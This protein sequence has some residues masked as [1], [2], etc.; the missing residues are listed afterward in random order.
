[1]LFLFSSVVGC[2]RMTG[3]FFRCSGSAFVGLLGL[4]DCKDGEVQS[5][6]PFASVCSLYFLI[7][8]EPYF[9]CFVLALFGWLGLVY[10]DDGG[11]QCMIS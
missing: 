1:M 8:F 4:V 2:L 10:R 7:F 3:A 6:L 11:V 5:L 9:G